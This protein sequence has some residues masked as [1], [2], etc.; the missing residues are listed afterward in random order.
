MNFNW[1]HFW[2]SARDDE[3]F[4]HQLALIILKFTFILVSRDDFIATP[5]LSESSE[6]FVNVDENDYCSLLIFSFR[7]GDLKVFAS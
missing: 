4:P 5:H 6:K 2:R 7:M 3:N 1:A